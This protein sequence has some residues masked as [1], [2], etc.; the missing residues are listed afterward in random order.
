MKH[1]KTTAAAFVLAA[2]I[3]S[4]LPALAQSETV[5]SSLNP[6]IVGEQTG[7][8]GRIPEGSVSAA[9]EDALSPTPDTG[10]AHNP[11]HV[12]K[13]ALFT[14]YA[15]RVF[16]PIWTEDGARSLIRAYAQ[17]PEMGLQLDE[18]ALRNLR[19]AARA[20]QSE[21]AEDAARADIT[22]STAFMRL[23]DR[24]LNGLDEV[25][26]EGADTPLPL[27]VLLAEA[28]TNTL[29]YDALSVEHAQYDDL[30]KARQTYEDYIKTGGFTPVPEPDG[31][32][33]LGD[34]SPVIET[35]RVRLLE[36][37]YSIE[38]PRNAA[39]VATADDDM[40]PL[41][42][43]SFIIAPGEPATVRASD[44]QDA[45]QTFTPEVERALRTFQAR[46]GLEVDGV[47]GPATVAA[48]NVTAEEKMA[49]IDA[50]LERWRQA[51]SDRGD[52]FIEVNIPAYRTRAISDGQVDIEMRSI[53]GLPTRQTPLMD[54]QIEYIVANPNWYVPTSILVRD[55]L[56]HIRE[57]TAYLGER[58]YKVLDRTTGQPLNADTI[59]WTSDEVA[60]QVR[61][62]QEPGAN[63]ALGEL[64]IMFPNRHAVY[65]HGT[66]GETLFERDQRAFSSGCIRLEDPQAM[67][68][69]VVEAVSGHDAEAQIASAVQSGENQRI[70]LETPLPVH[71]VYR[72]VE[73]DEQG[74]VIFHHDVYDRDPEL[75]ATMSAAP[76]SVSYPEQS[77]A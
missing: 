54:E 24:R 39:L 75:I 67:A 64:K 61:L 66:P 77:E 46:N 55:K 74:E 38:P 35:L 9:I 36:E 62:V 28:G 51:G 21:N 59:D 33:E 63:N 65:L 14:A 7:P 44:W 1:Y 29:D 8:A 57:D 11:D 56:D 32:L 43:V 13:Q 48:L 20:L 31:L 72:T 4:P 41:T 76:L 68:A 47:L 45:M 73:V 71:V 42:Q 26:L 19:H 69:W 53:V 3:S 22:L 10:H 49:R 18:A 23:A 27:D 58:G 12:V 34:T 52:Q 17:A 2:A 6:E 5:I 30:L 37:G 40:P 16:D 60:T 50:N 70:D 15:M 25:N